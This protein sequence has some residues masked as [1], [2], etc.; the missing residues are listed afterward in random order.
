MQGLV[1]QDVQTY[2][3]QSRTPNNLICKNDRFKR[4]MY[5]DIST[6]VDCVVSSLCLSIDQK[7]KTL[8]LKEFQGFGA[9]S[10]I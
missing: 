8:K 2:Y 6:F 3:Q 5:H 9:A 4:Q 10:Q 7:K 1:L